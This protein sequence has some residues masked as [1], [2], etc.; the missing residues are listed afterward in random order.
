LYLGMDKPAFE[1]IYICF[2]NRKPE[3]G[4]CKPETP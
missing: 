3:T 2:Q 1:I 4:N